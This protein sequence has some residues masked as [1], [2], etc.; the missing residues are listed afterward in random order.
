MEDSVWV[1]M[2]NTNAVNEKWAGLLA[3]GT[4]CIASSSVDVRCALISWAD[5]VFPFAAEPRGF[6]YRHLWISIGVG[7]GRWTH[8]A[9]LLWASH[10]VWTVRPDACDRLL[11]PATGNKHLDKDYNKDSLTDE[12]RKAE[13]RQSQQKVALAD[14][15]NQDHNQ[16]FLCLN[17]T[18]WCISRCRLVLC[19]CVYLPNAHRVLMPLLKLHPITPCFMASSFIGSFI[20]RTK[21]RSA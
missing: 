4:C 19:V 14:L 7:E 16:I 20:T 3:G 21:Q 17:T 8:G 5:R 11:L 18:V 13:S 1:L 12:L 10:T 15:H 6:R 2:K 9:H